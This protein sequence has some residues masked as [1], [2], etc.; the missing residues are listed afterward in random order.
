M[1]YWHDTENTM[2]RFSD[3]KLNFEEWVLSDAT[4]EQ[5][6]RSAV[7]ERNQWVQN[8]PNKNPKEYRGATVTIFSEGVAYANAENPK[9]PIPQ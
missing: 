3:G 4:R 5:T 8:N 2:W 9:A 7:T 6:W 1:A